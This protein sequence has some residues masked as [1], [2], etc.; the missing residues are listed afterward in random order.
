[1][2]S[3]LSKMKELGYPLPNDLTAGEIDQEMEQEEDDQQTQGT[4]QQSQ[5]PAAEEEEEE[6]EDEEEEYHMYSDEEDEEESISLLDQM[7]FLKIFFIMYFYILNISF[8][9]DLLPEF[10][11]YIKK[12]SLLFSLSRAFL[13]HVTS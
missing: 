1:M 12:N 5:K 3:I 11:I 6:E 10:Y 4:Q 9:S 13:S 8:Y 2:S 7:W